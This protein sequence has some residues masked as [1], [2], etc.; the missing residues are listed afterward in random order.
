[1]RLRRTDACVAVAAVALL[2]A[3]CGD[4]GGTDSSP[5]ERTDSAGV[6]VVRNGAPEWDVSA[7]WTVSAEPSLDIGRAEGDPAYELYG[8]TAAL[9]LD[10]GRIAVANGRVGEIRFFD[11]AGRHVATIGAE[12]EGPGEFRSIDGVWRL[13]PDSLLAWDRQLARWT[14]FAADGSLGRVI[15]PQPGGMNPGSLPPLEDGSLIVTDLWL[16]I[17]IGEPRTM[18]EHVLRYG[19]DGVLLDTVGRFPSF[20]GIATERG[21]IF[22]PIFGPRT[23]YSAGGDGFWIGYGTGY[24][25]L[26]FDER[27]ELRTRITWEGPDRTATGA[28]A[29]ADRQ[30]R[31]AVIPDEDARRDYAAQL[32]ELPVE[33]R[34]PAYEILFHD[35]EGCTWL[36]AY[37]KP[38]PVAAATRAWTVIDA[39][40][41][42]LGD[43]D[44][45][46]SLLPL[47]IGMDYILGVERDELDVEH[48]RLYALDRSGSA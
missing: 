21:A 11:A 48:V 41:R 40:G 33:E 46:A 29:E 2:S 16:D 4:P 5:F 14:V 9:R 10:D 39:A 45:P 13:G 12:G 1:M 19:A 32:A 28:D 24:E 18:Y 7:K 30:G 8:V 38:G 36:M 26:G 37:R 27:G 34:F 6:T 35:R 3:A 47:D 25:V 20:T 15:R 23:M 42:W 17:A 31:A 22:R 44:L 43:L